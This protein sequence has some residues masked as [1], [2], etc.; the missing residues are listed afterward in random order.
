M[1]LFQPIRPAS[2]EILDACTL[3]DMCDR[4]GYDMDSI[5]GEYPIW[6]EEQREWLNGEIYGYFA[7]REIGSETP[8]QFANYAQRVMNR[9]MPRVNSI[10]EFVLTGSQDWNLTASDESA[11]S[12]TTSSETGNTGSS[13]TTYD[14]ATTETPNLTN[15]SGTMT[16]TKATALMSDT[17]QVQLSGTENYMSSLNE[18][19]SSGSTSTTTTQTGTDTTATTGSDGTSS[20]SYTTQDG[21]ASSTATHTSSAGQ[22]SELASNWAETMPDLLG[23]IFDALE[24]CFMQVI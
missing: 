9:V 23:L 7:Y 19:G 5:L 12:S 1:M 10:A 2:F 14:H 17:P 8:A 20:T 18:S 3:Y 16:E 11:T 22:L 13:T 6:D 4:F 15:A 21:S 24:V